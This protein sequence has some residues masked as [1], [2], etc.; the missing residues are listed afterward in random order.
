M[1][2]IA[3]YNFTYFFSE[4]TF[5]NE[6]VTDDPLN[7]IK[8]TSN[9]IAAELL[10][11]FS[12]DLNPVAPKAQKKVPIPEGLDLDKWINEPPEE[13]DNESEDENVYDDGNIFVTKAERSERAEPT[14][15]D[16]YKVCSRFLLLCFFVVFWCFCNNSR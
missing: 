4:Q 10:Q 6:D 11:L 1:W 8:N 12:G 13:S 9:S 5:V 2:W 16:L 14:G 3:F 7:P 15:E